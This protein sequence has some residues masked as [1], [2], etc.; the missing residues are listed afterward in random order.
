V[1]IRPKK[2]TPTM[3]KKTAMPS[4]RRPGRDRERQHCAA[5][6]ATFPL[7]PPCE[8]EDQDRVLGREPASAA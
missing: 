7:Q 1:K 2:V 5:S 6:I 4:A 3:P 8:P